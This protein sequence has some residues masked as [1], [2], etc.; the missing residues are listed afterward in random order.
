MHHKLRLKGFLTFL[1][2]A[3]AHIWMLLTEGLSKLDFDA[4]TNLKGHKESLIMG[5][6]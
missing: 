3:V 2:L 1:M 4:V 6:L 5:I